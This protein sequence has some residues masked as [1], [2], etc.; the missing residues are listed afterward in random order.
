MVISKL[1]FSV[2]RALMSCMCCCWEQSR[3]TLLDDSRSLTT[4]ASSV[5]WCEHS[6]RWT[7]LPG[8]FWWWLFL[9]L[10]LLPE[11][12]GWLWIRLAQEQRGWPP[13]P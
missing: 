8:L 6:L 10:I 4:E 9:A 2:E 1:Y 5:T 13:A 3:M 12:L 11:L 7:R